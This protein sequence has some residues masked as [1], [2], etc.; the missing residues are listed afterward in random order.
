MQASGKRFSREQGLD[1]T[2]FVLWGEAIQEWCQPTQGYD[3]GVAKFSVLRGPV[4][5]RW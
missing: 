4:H 2:I 5:V 3:P 1:Y